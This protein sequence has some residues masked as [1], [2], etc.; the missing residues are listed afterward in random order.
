MATA[1]RPRGGFVQADYKQQMPGA[2]MRARLRLTDRKPDEVLAVRRAVADRRRVAEP[3]LHGPGHE[4][5]LHQRERLPS[6]RL[7][8]RRR[9]GA[10]EKEAERDRKQTD[11]GFRHNVA[12]SLEGRTWPKRAMSP[13]P[14]SDIVHGRNP[15]VAD[16]VNIGGNGFTCLQDRGDPGKPM[17]PHI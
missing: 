1:L 15:P 6:V 5:R 17:V 2:R 4:A 7:N 9:A 13:D 3:R 12:L 8:A 14:K 11:G 16:A 10:E